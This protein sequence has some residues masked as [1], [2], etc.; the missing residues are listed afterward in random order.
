VELFVGKED[1]V[2]SVGV[3][4]S[5]LEQYSKLQKCGL[6][7]LFVV[8]RWR[9][10]IGRKGLNKRIPFKARIRAFMAGK[11]SKGRISF[12]IAGESK[13]RNKHLRESALKYSWVKQRVVSTFRAGI[14]PG[15]C[16]RLFTMIQAQ[17]FTNLGTHHAI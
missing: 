16:S 15:Q 7:T 6:G 8:M 17:T 13:Q 10:T 2:L 4:I 12:L 14:G 1:D 9:P 5:G 3:A 11:R